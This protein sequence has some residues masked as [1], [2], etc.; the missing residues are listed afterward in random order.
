MGFWRH[1]DLKLEP[2]SS[3]N[4]SFGKLFGEMVTFSKPW[5]LPMKSLS[6]GPWGYQNLI[7]ITFAFWYC[8]WITFFS[9]L[10]LKSVPKWEP[11]SILL[12][13]WVP[14]GRSRSPMSPPS[15]LQTPILLRN[16]S[17]RPLPESPQT[18]KHPITQ[19]PRPPKRGPAAEA[20]AFRI[21]YYIVL[22]YITYIILYIILAREVVD[23]W[24][25]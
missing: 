19:P 25:E 7:K 18:P 17:P 5:Y 9:I 23:Q 14:P 20:S 15:V 8:F 24:G 13:S 3:Q 11:K 4:R 22:Y 10:A 21:N 2:K 1:F 6:W 12:T 16:G